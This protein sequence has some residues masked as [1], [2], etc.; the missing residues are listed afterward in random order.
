MKEYKVGD[1]VSFV[2]QGRSYVGVIE[3]RE[4]Y[5][6]DGVFQFL[7]TILVNENYSETRFVNMRE[8]DIQGISACP[9]GSARQSAPVKAQ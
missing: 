6:V 2:M 9:P 8:P 4:R 1:R 7:Y 3:Q 5:K